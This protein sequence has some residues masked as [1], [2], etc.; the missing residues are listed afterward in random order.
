MP[1][2]NREML[3]I[4]VQNLNEADKGANSGLI[5]SPVLKSPHM[6]M[7]GMNLMLILGD[8]SALQLVKDGNVSHGQ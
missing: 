8:L 5:K 7:V 6:K 4:K 1:E 3:E 2:A